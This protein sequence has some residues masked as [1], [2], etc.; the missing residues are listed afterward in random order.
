MDE[1]KTIPLSEGGAKVIFES[2]SIALY[3]GTDSNSEE[4]QRVIR[5]L[6]IAYPEIAELYNF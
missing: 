3:E 1:F 2:I 6:K 4:I 5:V